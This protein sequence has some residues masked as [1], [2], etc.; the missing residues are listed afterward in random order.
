MAGYIL[1][2]IQRKLKGRKEAKVFIK[3]IKIKINAPSCGSMKCIEKGKRM[4]TEAK[5]QINEQMRSVWGNVKAM[6]KEKGNQER[7]EFLPKDILVSKK[8]KKW[9]WL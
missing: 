7:M 9:W 5:K 1:K 6:R 4:E 8:Q 3:K 2:M